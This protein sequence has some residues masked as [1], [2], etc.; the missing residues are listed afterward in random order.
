MVDFE[1][2]QVPS[3]ILREHRAGDIGWVIHRHGVL[4]HEEF[5]WDERF[6]GLVAE[7]LGQF[8]KSHD[9]R[10]IAHPG[11]TAH[12]GMSDHPCERSWVACRGDRGRSLGA[13][14]TTDG[15]R[16]SGAGDEIL[17]CVFLVRVDEPGS[18]MI[19]TCKL[20][21]LL[22]E[23]AARGMG[24][25]GRLVDECIAFARGCGYER[26]ILWTNSVLVSARKIYESRGFRMIEEKPHELFAAS[27]GEQLIGQTWELVL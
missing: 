15:P 3:Y 10:M 16:V 9:R 13:G 19:R 4:Y 25:G 27:S 17:G 14:G 11:M 18:P 21:C 6:E 24:L 5:G 12:P 7:V 1:R 23:P 8:L 22:V 20:R 2:P 26:M